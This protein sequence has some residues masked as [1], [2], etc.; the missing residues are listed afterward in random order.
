[1]GPKRASTGGLRDAPY[2]C[3]YFDIPEESISTEGQ[4]GSARIFSGN[5]F[6]FLMENRFRKFL[7]G[8]S[9]KAFMWL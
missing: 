3:F 4:S 7:F 9:N 2:G 5:L 6:A 1:M 8:F